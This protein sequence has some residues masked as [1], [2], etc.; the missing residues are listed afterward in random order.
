MPILVVD[1]VREDRVAT[2]KPN[3]YEKQAVWSVR[4]AGVGLLAAVAALVLIFRNFEFDAATLH[5][6]RNGRSFPLMLAGIGVA[7]LL[8]TIGFFMGFSSAGHSR[9]KRSN[10][11]WLGFFLSA[12]AVSLGLAA[13]IFYFFTK[14]DF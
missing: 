14:L 4:L 12:A 11:S 2:A 5:M 1:S 9:N 13:L 8:G 3:T 10:L 7:C 6:P